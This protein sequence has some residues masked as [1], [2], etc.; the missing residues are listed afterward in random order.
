MQPSGVLSSY[1]RNVEWRKEQK[2]LTLNALGKC[3]IVS[4]AQWHSRNSCDKTKTAEIIM[5]SFQIHFLRRTS[6]HLLQQSK[7]AI[8]RFALSVPR[9]HE[10]KHHNSCNAC[11]QKCHLENSLSKI[12][13]P[14]AGA[15][16]RVHNY[17]LVRAICKN[18]MSWN[19]LPNRWLPSALETYAKNLQIKLDNRNLM[20]RSFE[21]PLQLHCRMEYNHKCCWRGRYHSNISPI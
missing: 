8:E 17:V 16:V 20:S 3:C 9:S 18:S 4:G 11:A 6:H 5:L 13:A 21:F 10:T 14:A 7:S 1:V 19:D 15:K 2:Q 12:D